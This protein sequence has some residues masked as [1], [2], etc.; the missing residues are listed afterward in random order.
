MTTTIEIRTSIIIADII[1]I[2]QVK[3]N[4]SKECPGFFTLTRLT[5]TETTCDSDQQ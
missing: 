2:L 5:E 4:S 3:L 1:M